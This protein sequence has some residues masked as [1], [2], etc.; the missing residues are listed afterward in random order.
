MCFFCIPKFN[1]FFLAWTQIIISLRLYLKIVYDDMKF[2]FLSEM[3]CALFPLHFI[4]LAESD[5]CVFHHHL[6]REIIPGLTGLY[7]WKNVTA[8][9]IQRLSNLRSEAV[10]C[11]LIDGTEPA[12]MNVIQ[13]NE[14]SVHPVFSL[15][16][17]WGDNFKVNMMPM[18]NKEFVLV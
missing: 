2:R 12:L 18:H 11:I 15:C 13:L 7:T 16:D 6:S 14:N 5:L 1:Y 10:S 3:G 4:S 9:K 17:S 8:N